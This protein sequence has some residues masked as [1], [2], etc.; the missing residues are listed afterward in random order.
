LDRSAEVRRFSH[1][2]RRSN[3]ACL[4]RVKGSGAGA[5]E[6]RVKNENP[7]S[8]AY[9]GFLS[10]GRH[11]SF[12]LLLGIAIALGVGPAMLVGH[13]LRCPGSMFAKDVD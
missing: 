12:K 7:P 2:A 3:V 1:G 10:G 5:D 4:L 11:A 8:S 6:W 13:R 9:V